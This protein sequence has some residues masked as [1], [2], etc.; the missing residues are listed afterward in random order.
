[1]APVKV[2]HVITRHSLGGAEQDLKHWM[3]CERERGY[4]V[5]LV[6]GVDSDASTL[7]SGVQTRILRTLVRDPAPRNDLQTLRSLRQLI[8]HEEYDVVHTHQSKAGVLGRMAARG[9]ARRIIH[10]VHIPSFGPGF[11]ALP[12]RAFLAAERHCGRF[13]DQYVCVGNDVLRRYVESGVAPSDRFFTVRTPIAIDQFT[14][15]RSLTA[16]ERERC[17]ESLGVP[18]GIP[19]AAAIGSLERRKRHELAIRELAPL[20]RQG[21]LHLVIAGSGTE[22][23]RLS[24]L[25]AELGVEDSVQ[26]LGHVESPEQ[27][28]A[29]A[30]V[31]VHTARVEGVCRVFVEAAAAG[32]PVVSTDVEG[33]REVLGVTVVARDGSGMAEAVGRV[34]DAPPTPVDPDALS[35]WK[36]SSVSAQ[37]DRFQE[38]LGIDV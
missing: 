22:E 35:E 12:S 1:L 20:L 37:F 29:V 13:T 36:P 7:P 19:V 38:R 14:A 6:C 31:L 33:A 34:L 9:R 4:D 27:L 30:G 16:A 15:V 3:S 25:A 11:G 18:L 5:A 10:T 17:R 24:E 2:L 21:R 8:D 23:R 28:L 32:V 26:L